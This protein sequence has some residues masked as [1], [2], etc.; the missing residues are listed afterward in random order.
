ME[1]AVL[2]QVTVDI[3]SADKTVQL[4]ATGSVVK[5]NG[6]LTLYD[7]GR[8]ENDEEDENGAILPD[9]AEAEALE[10]REVIPSSISPSRRRAIPRPAWSRSSRS[11]ASAG[12][13]PTPAS[14][15]CCSAATT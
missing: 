9:V 8:D 6:F 14:S 12:P 3:A 13:R 11:S 10:R 4:R 2:D 5:F 15:R 1:S 7:E